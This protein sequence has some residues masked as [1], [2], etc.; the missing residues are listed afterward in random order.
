MSD[1]LP[2]FSDVRSMAQELIAAWAPAQKLYDDCEAMYFMRDRQAEAEAKKRNMKLTYSPDARNKLE[3]AVRLLVATD[4]LFTIEPTGDVD[5]R[6]SQLEQAAQLM[7]AASGKINGTPVH[8]DALLS[9]MLYDGV[10][11]SLT[12]TKEL[13]RY[14]QRQ[15]KAYKARMDWIA[16]RTPI[17]FDVWSARDCYPLYD[18]FGL[19][20]H[21]HR[22]RARV[23]DVIGAW[24]DRAASLTKRRKT[25]WVDVNEWWDLD[26]HTVWVTDDREPILH[27]PN[28]RP[29]IPVVSGQAYGSTRLFGKIED[30]VQPF[31]YIARQSGL[32]ARQNLALT[33]L[34][35]QIF[36]AGFAPP[37]AHVQAGDGQPLTINTDGPMPVFELHKDERLD[38]VF[39]SI[40]DPAMYQ[41]MQV[42]DTK[43]TESTIYS[44]ALGQSLG[45]DTYST[46]ALLSQAGRLPLVSPQ[47]RIGWL[48]GRAME[49]AFRLLKV[50]GGKKRQI[51]ADNKAAEIRP[52]DIPDDLSVEAALDITLP[53]DKL[54]LAQIAIALTGGDDP[55]TSKNWARN[56]ILNIGQSDEHQTEIWSEQVAKLFASM[57]F[58]DQ[59]ALELRSAA[60]ASGGAPGGA[61][62]GMQQDPAAA[63]GLPPVMQGV[64][65]VMAMGGGQGPMPLNG[66]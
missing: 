36:R 61:P 66:G 25:E 53:Q 19:A 33:V 64:P 28:T 24:G 39:K 13:V 20:A 47:R 38:Q 3:G 22:T 54:Q 45:T 62:G 34:F 12:S 44:Q 30:Q 18:R 49:V 43:M 59:A 65:D 52:A 29:L 55:L 42:A 56:E 60:G 1:T 58:R 46:V 40:V 21:L 11:I 48:I 14:A 10:H 6:S 2:E 63:A 50:E 9:A 32:W 51:R 31:L 26:V 7:W 57:F 23:S 41:A 4:P 15:S 35:T 5:D 17:L 27:L 37:L 8:Y 16:A